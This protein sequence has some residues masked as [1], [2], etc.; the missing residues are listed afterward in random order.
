[1]G[2]LPS[3]DGGPLERVLKNEQAKLVRRVL[4]DLG[5]E[6]DRQMLFRFYVAEEDKADICAALGLSS[7]QFNRVLFRAR[8]R[9][10]ELYE[11]AANQGK[12][13]AG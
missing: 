5:L 1:M 8:Q 9:Y 4:A 7:L 6:R 10:K 12:G 3:P 13:G 2:D 11:R